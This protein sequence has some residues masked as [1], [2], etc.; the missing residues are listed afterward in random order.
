MTLIS[1]YIDILKRKQGASDIAYLLFLKG[2]RSGEI[3]VQLRDNSSK[4]RSKINRY[5]TSSPMAS[6]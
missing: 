5:A 1:M 3:K 2:K 6:T 4:Q